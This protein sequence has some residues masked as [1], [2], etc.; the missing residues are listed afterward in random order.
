MAGFNY[1]YCRAA[2]GGSVETPNAAALLRLMQLACVKSAV[3]GLMH[4]S[5]QHLYSVAS[6]ARTSNEGGTVRPSALAVFMLITSS[7]F[8]GCHRARI[9]ATRW[10]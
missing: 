7:N 3:T 8:V 1:R 4:R 6:S 5:K 2:P 9:R 10:L